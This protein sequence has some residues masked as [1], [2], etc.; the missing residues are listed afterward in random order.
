[1]PAFCAR[2]RANC[3]PNPPGQFDQAIP[4]FGADTSPGNTC[5]SAVFASANCAVIMVRPAV[6]FRAFLSFFFLLSL[7]SP[8]FLRSQHHIDPNGRVPAENLCRPIPTRHPLAADG[9]GG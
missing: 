2:G 4:G 5:R 6:Q 1:M 9:V 7:F 8:F 3:A